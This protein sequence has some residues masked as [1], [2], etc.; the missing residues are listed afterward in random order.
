MEIKDIVAENFRVYLAINNKN[1]KDV[2]E[3][4]G[5]SRTTL[6]NLKNGYSEGVRY[7]TLETLAKEFNTRPYEFFVERSEKNDF[8]TKN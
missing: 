4:T 1:I 3:S 8:R 2:F 5:I 7:K 6:S